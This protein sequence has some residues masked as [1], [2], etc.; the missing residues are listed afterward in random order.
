MLQ[1]EPGPRAPGDSLI[2]RMRASGTLTGPDSSLMAIEWRVVY[3][4]LAL[5]MSRCFV[6]DNCRHRQRPRHLI[7]SETTLCYGRECV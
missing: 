7:V 3:G 4:F 2:A 1:P 6:A 5:L